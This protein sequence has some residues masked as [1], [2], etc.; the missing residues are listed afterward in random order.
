MEQLGSG[1]DVVVAGGGTAGIIAALQSARLGAKT[2]IVE[3]TGQLGGT[4]T[5]GGINCVLF[6][7]AWG[8]QVIA[9]LGWELVRQCLEF[10]GR[11]MP[12]FSK[13]PQPAGGFGV[14][15]SAPLFACL[16][17]QACLRAG[18]DL[19]YHELPISARRDQ[20][21]VLETAGKGQRRI[22]RCRELIDCTGDADLVDLAGFS[23]EKGEELQP[24]TLVAKLAG[25]D[26]DAL[27]AEMVQSQYESAMRDGRLQ[28]GDF[29]YADMEKFVVYLRSCGGN[30]QHVPD[31]DG[32]SSAGK[33]LANRRG[34]ESA[35]RLLRFVRSLP[36][37][38]KAVL[39]DLK[40]EAAIRETFRIVGEKRITREDFLAG[41]IYE[42]A[43]CYS[44]YFIDLHT[45]SGVTKE[46][47][48]EGVVPT[49]P[50]GA[51]IPK[52]SR[53]LL[54]AGRSVSS[55]RMAN[56]ALRVQASCMAMGQA[57][58]AAA[59][60]GIQSGCAS[61]DVGLCDLRRILRAHGAI[62]PGE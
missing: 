61:R 21:W 35:L 30:T 52:G 55:D 17:E 36:G 29:A 41:R 3:W 4:I 43:V 33:S 60:L 19:L 25:Y 56:S 24:A 1:Y 12:D 39:A 18:V 16:A 13:S 34:R 46:F 59:A 58:G 14:V 40:S 48:R 11:P 7:S 22:I 27:E 26:R 44:F 49:V 10:E 15:F 47:L 51:L 50:F 57:A 6:L 31:V 37:C 42:D 54:S 8:R 38:E 23:R 9:G 2:A 28:A 20:N 5:N 62:V 45:R 53:H 32:G